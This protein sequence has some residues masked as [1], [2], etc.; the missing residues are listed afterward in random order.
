MCLTTFKIFY[1]KTDLFTS[2][3]L[4]TRQKGL[5]KQLLSGCYNCIPP[6][7]HR[8]LPSSPKSPR[9]CSYQKTNFFDS[10]LKA[11][12]K[13]NEMSWKQTNYLAVNLKISRIILDPSN[14]FHF[15][16]IST[17][18]SGTFLE[19]SKSSNLNWNLARISWKKHEQKEWNPL[20]GCR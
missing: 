6:V 10:H 18:I 7:A 19:T 20:N 15:S 8:N 5:H 1:S 16:W 14:Y 4:E 13:N 17:E 2:T 3:F 11:T 12:S 9:I